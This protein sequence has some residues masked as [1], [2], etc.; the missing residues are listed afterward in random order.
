MKV[1]TRPLFA[2]APRLGFTV[3]TP[4]RLEDPFG[5]A[6]TAAVMLVLPWRIRAGS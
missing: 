1:N 3:K 4:R 2:D 5:E 6:D